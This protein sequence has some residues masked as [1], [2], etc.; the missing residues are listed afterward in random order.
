MTRACLFRASEVR[1]LIPFVHSLCT[2]LFRKIEIANALDI[3][4]L[5]DSHEAD[6]LLPN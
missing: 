4:I 3:L 6:E 2:V 1:A 5:A